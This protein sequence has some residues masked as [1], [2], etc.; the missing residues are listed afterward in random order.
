MT[1]FRSQVL[2]LLAAVTLSVC[3]PANADVPTPPTAP[4][5]PAGY[6]STIYNELQT[7]LTA[8]NQ[9][10]GNPAPYPTLNIAQLRMADAN[11]GPSISGP[12]YLAAV[13]AQLQELQAMGV[14]GVAVQVGFPALYEPFY[15]S[16][17]ALAP[18]TSFY[19]QLGQAVRAAG[20]KLI[21]END[22]LLASGSDAGWTNLT[23]YYSTLNW[24]QYVAARAAM[25]A[26][27]AQTMQPD[28][29]ILA[30]EP[31][32]EAA[33]SGQSNLNDPV[34]A[35]AMIASE[36]VSVRLADLNVKLGAGVGSW[37][38]PTGTG[39]LV[40]YLTNYLLL[41]LDYID[42]HVYPINTVAGGSLLGNALTIISMAAAALKPVAVSEAWLWKMEDSEWGVLTVDTFRARYPFG[43]WAPLD[44][45]FLQTMAKLANYAQM[46]YLSF[47]GTNYFLTYQDFGG[48]AANGGAASCTCTTLSCNAAEI[49]ADENQMA[50][51]ADQIANFTTT[52]FAYN[53][54]LVP[55][56][57][58]T[59]PSNPSAPTGTAGYNSATFSW[60]GS[61]DNVGVAGYN[62]YRCSPPSQGQ[63]CT[64]A[65]ISNS[66]DTSF[67]DP[68]LTDNTPYNYQVQAFDFKNNLSAMSAVLSLQTYN[69][70]PPSSPTAV[71]ATAVSPSEI[72]LSWAA[73]QNSTGLNKYLLYGGTST[74]NLNVVA[75]IPATKTSYRN[76]PLAPATQYFYGMVAVE[77]GINSPMSAIVSATTLPLPNSPTSLAAAASSAT[78]ITLSWQ[79][80][81]PRNG[82]PISNYQVFRGTTLGQMI[83]L[84]Q[85]TNTTRY[86][87]SGLTP[88][89]KYYYQIVAVDTSN[90]KSVP[91]A[92]VSGTPPPMPNPPYNTLATANSTTR[93]TV[94]WSETVP[95]GG[96]SI[97]AYK[98]YRSK[99]LPVT[100]ANY[101]ASRTTPSYI[102]TTATPST[103]YYYAIAAL[104]TG[105][106]L[107]AL[108]NTASAT[109]PAPPNAPANVQA[110]ANSSTKV[111][112]TWSETIPSGGLPIKVYKI[113]RSLTLPVTTADYVA[114]R[115][116]PTYIDTTVV[117]GTGYYYAIAAQDTGGDLS[118]LSAP[119][120]VTTP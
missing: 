30:E 103:T 116:T 22:V 50:S 21:V 71:A 55:A 35:A 23:S 66:A 108:S 107:S 58:T 28:Y 59:A 79:E 39:S 118:P 98:I 89:T 15:G 18:Y 109:T 69:N 14:K 114:S 61:T 88:G 37:L 1:P 112:V 101:V 36:I 24:T 74:S 7:D 51:A 3:P 115:T 75:T 83:L 17:S 97:R 72:D 119:A 20:L 33:N 99:T 19:Q 105:N 42:F 2:Y 104:D 31:D 62:V 102:D 16:A 73:P 81:I 41:P 111:T 52:G 80:V 110:T 92:P 26:T 67:A 27:L 68:G 84:P 96:L 113:Y 49:E 9:S 106:D 60:T 29:L 57:D 76:Q 85:R 95:P 100:T 93:I 6:C 77:G 34:Q 90:N 86:T 54:L 11:T 44:A 91:S 56:P 63:A 8:F 87:D 120:H 78:K 48:T 46:E 65:W 47:D 40:N 53:D 5:P 82:L 94:T 45:Y 117:T 70:T 43:F 12:N 64:P 32:T 10:L 25:A 4:P 38:G 13:E